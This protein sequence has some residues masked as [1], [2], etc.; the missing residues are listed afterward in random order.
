MPNYFESYYRSVQ[1]GILA[2]LACWERLSSFALKETPIFS[3]THLQGVII[4]L[5]INMQ[6]SGCS[7]DEIGITSSPIKKF[8]ISVPRLQSDVALLLLKISSTS[9]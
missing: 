6:I 3:R 8:V 5:S 7:G 9:P 4:A 1:E 2:F